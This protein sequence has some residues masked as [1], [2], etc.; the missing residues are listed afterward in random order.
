MKAARGSRGGVPLTRALG[1]G[2]VP[3]WAAPQLSKGQCQFSR[4][5]EGNGCPRLHGDRKFPDSEVISES[6]NLVVET[7][8]DGNPQLPGARRLRGKDLRPGAPGVSPME[9]QAKY[10]CLCV[11]RVQ[12]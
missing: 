11:S 6:G 1:C 3:D 8:T 10:A 4:V 2:P 7:D 12:K 9:I 5:D